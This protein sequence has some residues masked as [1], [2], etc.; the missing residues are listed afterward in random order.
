MQPQP[1]KAS[2]YAWII[3]AVSFLVSALIA[4]INTSYGVFLVPLSR[5]FG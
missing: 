2:Y 1:W 3:L 5:Q 4:G